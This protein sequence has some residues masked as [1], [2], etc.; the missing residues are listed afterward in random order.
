MRLRIFVEPQQGASYQTLRDAAR[1]AEA[2]GFD[3][4]F[5][6]DHYLKMGSTDGLPGPTDAWTTLAGLACDTSAIRL[7]TLVTSATFRLPG[8][9][10]ITVAQVDQMS[11][12]R[13]ELGLG[14]GWYD[15]EHTA[16]GIPFPAL[17][18]RFVRLEEQLGAIVG[19]WTT[20]VGET[21]TA[22]GTYY[23][24]ADS[25]ALPKPLQ[26]PHPPV[27]VGGSGAKRTPRLAATFAQE[28]NAPFLSPA[29]AKVQYARADEA[30]AAI[31]R[32]P[33]TLRRSFAI[34]TCCGRDDAELAR[35]AEASG[36]KLEDLRH[37]GAC[38][39]PDE[40]AERL[41]EWRDAGAELAYLQLLD[42]SDLDHIELL[43]SALLP[44]V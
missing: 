20:P 38:G 6:S 19:L 32:D 13:V 5:R 26:R 23:A 3:G 24:F 40:V 12:G 35:R 34:T 22:T 18:E 36:W 33:A 17:D 11:G 31:G 25:P 28:Y 2:A 43:G 30:C 1:C 14:A 15:T 8:P 7:G 4:F 16:Y 29:D 39:T 10:A 42:P 44:L 27:I 41:G 9:L 37:H 21:F